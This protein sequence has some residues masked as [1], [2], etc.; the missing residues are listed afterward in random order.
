L[1]RWW[2]VEIV[3][4]FSQRFMRKTGSA[5][6]RYFDSNPMHVLLLVLDIKKLPLPV[7]KLPFAYILRACYFFFQM[8]LRINDC[9]LPKQH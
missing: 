4:L 3:L 5:R 1:L 2:D 6:G 9:C 8:T 7:K